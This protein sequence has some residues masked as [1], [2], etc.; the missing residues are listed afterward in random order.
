MRLEMIRCAAFLPLLAL[1]GS[2]GGDTGGGG[3]APPV[4]VTPTP[5][6]APTPTPTPP[7]VQY[8]S[9]TA[10]D[11]DMNFQSPYVEVS[12]YHLLDK[13]AP[14]QQPLIYERAAG[15]IAASRDAATLTWNAD[16]SAT[17]RAGN[18]FRAFPSTLFSSAGPVGFSFVDSGASGTTHFGWST[19]AGL[20]Q[21]LASSVV[22]ESAAPDP[23]DGDAILRQYRYFIPGS[24]TQDIDL[25]TTGSFVY[26]GY[27]LHS[28]TTRIAGESS[29]I[30][31]LSIDLATGRVT[32]EWLAGP[33]RLVIAGTVTR[34]ATLR[35]S[36][37]VKDSVGLFDGTFVGDLYGPQAKEAGLVLITRSKDFVIGGQ[38]VGARML[39]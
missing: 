21:Y 25:P 36:G 1:V 4:T 10:F 22:R 20:T 7:P 18:Y 26:Q 33:Y 2:C 27:F 28:P 8:G 5:S 32:G 39:P 19:P 31:F 16:K 29:A 34:S 13:A 11:R 12:Y 17:L 38:F 35:L 9:V 30:V 3:N 23:N 15:T 37:T 14:P 6:P 24:R